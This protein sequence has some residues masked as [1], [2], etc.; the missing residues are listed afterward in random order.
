MMDR[1]L[2]E[3][4]Q[5][6][7]QEILQAHPKGLSEYELIG[8]LQSG[9][10]PLFDQ[11]IFHD[12][13]N[14][15][16][17]HFLL[18]HALY[19]LR[20]QLLSEQRASLQIDPLRIRWLAFAPRDRG[21]LDQPDPLRAYYLDL[22]HLENTGREDIERML[23]K[24]W[25]RLYADEHRSDALRTLDLQEPVDYDTIRK[26]YRELVMRHHPDRGGDTQ[27]LQELN[28]AMTILARVYAP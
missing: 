21:Q 19:R 27:R 12:S 7:L 1:G 9:A 5:L 20:E 28:E 2:L 15:F 25:S 18:F 17:A 23:G 4:L 26:R 6:R 11:D 3:A 8:M 13:V 10:Q 16:R 14:L 24:F 22:D